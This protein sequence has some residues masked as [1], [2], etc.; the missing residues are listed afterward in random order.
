MDS[1]KISYITYKHFN[2]VGNVLHTIVVTGN[3]VNKRGLLGLVHF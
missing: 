1:A 2:N 3:H